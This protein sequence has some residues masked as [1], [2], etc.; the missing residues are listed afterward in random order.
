[1]KILLFFPP[2]WHYPYL[3]HLSLPTLSAYLIR[4]GF[5]VSVRD[6]NIEQFHLDTSPPGLVRRLD[7]IEGE[8]DKLARK[9]RPDRG[10]QALY[11]QLSRARLLYPD[12]G[13]CQ[14]LKTFF[15][16]NE[17]FY[18]EGAFRSASVHMGRILATVFRPVTDRL[19]G[20]A[21]SSTRLL[22]IVDDRST[23]PYVAYFREITSGLESA[24]PD[25][26]GISVATSDQMVPAFTLA[27]AIKESR[28]GI[29]V[30]M[31]GSMIT[32]IIGEIAKA[33]GLFDL[34]DFFVEGEGEK[35]LATLARALDEGREPAD[36]P[37]LL[38]RRGGSVRRGGPLS[39]IDL[40]GLPTPSFDALPLEAYLS[41][42]PVLPYAASRGCPW[43]R[44][45]F[46]SGKELEGRRWR[47]KPVGKVVDD[48]EALIQSHNAGVFFF[49]DNLI[50]SAYLFELG[51]EI[52]DR[53]LDVTWTCQTRPGKGFAKEGIEQIA[54]AGCGTLQFGLESGSRRILDLMGKGIDPDEAEEIFSL[55]SNAGISVH[56][57]C[58]FGFPGERDEEARETLQMINRARE[59]FAKSGIT[60]T[61]QSFVLSRGSEV[62]LDPDSFGLEAALEPP[63]EDLSDVL[64]ARRR[65]STE[66]FSDVDS[67]SPGL[68]ARARAGLKGSPAGPATNLVH[69]L[70]F[71]RRF[72]ASHGACMATL[73]PDR[74]VEPLFP[75]GGER[76]DPVKGLR[77]VEVKCLEGGG[78]TRW[79]VR[80]GDPR[81][82]VEIGESEKRFLQTCDG[83]R[84]LDEIAAKLA[85]HDSTAQ[86]YAY[87]TLFAGKGILKLT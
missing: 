10:D 11:D 51:R 76:P 83:K 27:R 48:L 12:E 64:V 85:P 44:C 53:G 62:S 3:P 52:E 66:P 57:Y 75:S 21:G 72:G 43:G 33:E 71:R 55:C 58:M 34:V 30:V 28:P 54:G 65:A 80:E 87:G 5:S 42:E 29:S 41:P 60:V 35:A 36:V 61:L 25:V 63:G 39:A 14:S 84:T 32:R 19:A 6:L 16:S 45:T 15:R 74:P 1:M 49:T 38:Y 8:R 17:E 59:R 24:S 13:T 22:E 20:Y 56:L 31:G 68:I 26:V 73:Q 18:D 9:P 79:L 77:F 23:N 78:E 7:W 46:C 2:G 50:P 4:E 70:F 40:G 69:A 81:A 37:G 82:V 47:A 67:A 86:I